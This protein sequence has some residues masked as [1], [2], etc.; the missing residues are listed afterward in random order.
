MCDNMNCNAQLDD[1]RLRGSRRDCKLRTYIC[2]LCSLQ[3]S[4]LCAF[5]SRL[6]STFRLL[7]RRLSSQTSPLL[8][9][10]RILLEQDCC[11]RPQRPLKMS[12]KT[13]LCIAIA[14]VALTCAQQQDPNIKCSTECVTKQD[15][16]YSECHYLGPT[17][18]C[19]NT[20]CVDK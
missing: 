16:V 18:Q 14:T 7:A 2:S 4:V 9:S 12:V 11:S 15:E 5:S 19:C 10:Y 1:S 13:S 3:S 20:Y 8:L 17:L 6:S